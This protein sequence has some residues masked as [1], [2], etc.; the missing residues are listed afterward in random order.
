M[1]K[2]FL[3]AVR[4]PQRPIYLPDQRRRAQH[5]PTEPKSQREG[6]G[7]RSKLRRRSVTSVQWLR[8]SG[9]K[10]PHSQRGY[11]ARREQRNYLRAEGGSE[12]RPYKTSA[13][14]PSPEP[15]P[16]AIFPQPVK[17]RKT[18]TLQTPEGG[19]AAKPLALPPEA[20]FSATSKAHATSFSSSQ[21]ARV[22][23]ARGSFCAAAKAG[24]ISAK[25]AR[26]RSMSASVWAT[27][28]VHC[29]SHQYGCGITPRL[30]MANQ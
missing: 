16:K 6:C 27:E 12:T 2:W 18:P 26:W 30:T 10:P 23:A 28:I 7:R 19:A 8:K 14:R 3:S 24:A 15:P 22:V 29:S 9:G 13:R 11:L 4:F 20:T 21:W 5:V 25:A 1:A 17:L